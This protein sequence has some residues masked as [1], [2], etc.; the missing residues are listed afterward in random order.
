MAPGKNPEQWL[1]C[2]YGSFVEFSLSIGW[3][4][5]RKLEGSHFS[6]WK[7]GKLWDTKAKMYCCLWRSSRILFASRENS[8][9]TSEQW[10]SQSYWT[11]RA[12]LCMCKSFDHTHWLTSLGP[13]HCNQILQASFRICTVLFDSDAS[14]KKA[15]LI[16]HRTSWFIP[17]IL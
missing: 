8:V 14:G 5:V 9:N 3:L 17:C 6:R 16:R 2:V 13:C 7:K 12:P 11:G 4:D 1:A 15:G 10:C